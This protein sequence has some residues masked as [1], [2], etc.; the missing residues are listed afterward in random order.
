MG[1]ERPHRR[2]LA[3][4]CCLIVLVPLT[5][6]RHAGGRPCGSDAAV[7]T[8]ALFLPLAVPKSVLRFARLAGI[9]SAPAPHPEEPAPCPSR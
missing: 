7:L 9:G 8:A 3:L 4:F 1:R 2:R 5:V 6:E